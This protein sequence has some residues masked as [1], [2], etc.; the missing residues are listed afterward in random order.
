M[1]LAPYVLS[2]LHRFPA[3]FREVRSLKIFLRSRFLRFADKPYL[4]AI[5]DTPLGFGR[6]PM[7]TGPAH[8][9]TAAMLGIW[10]L[11]ATSAPTASLRPRPLPSWPG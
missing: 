11:G 6:P 7:S 9:L 5:R 4:R 2:F 1:L 3:P 8:L 10:G